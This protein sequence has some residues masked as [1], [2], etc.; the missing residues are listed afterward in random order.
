MALI[1][2]LTRPDGLQGVFSCLSI[3]QGLSGFRC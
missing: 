1:S 3:V 2:C